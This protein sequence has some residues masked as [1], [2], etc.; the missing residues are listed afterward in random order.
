M[1]CDFCGCKTDKNFFTDDLTILCKKCATAGGFYSGADAVQFIKQ[2][3]QG[4]KK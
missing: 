1:D 4:G 2:Q 3:A